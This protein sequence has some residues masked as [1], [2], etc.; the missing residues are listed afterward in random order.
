MSNRFVHMTDEEILADYKKAMHQKEQVQI[1]ADLNAVS[2]KEMV[3]F[4]YE[5]GVLSNSAIGAYKRS[6]LLPADA[7]NVTS[8]EKPD[9]TEDLPNP[10]IPAVEEKPK[11]VNM[12]CAAIGIVGDWLDQNRKEY[13]YA[14]AF[15][16]KYELLMKFCS[17]DY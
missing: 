10:D 3:Q 12:I 6:K 11:D 5:K 4:L 14:K 7:D 15:S 8:N 2:K 9:V 13:E 16:D 17:E 1:L